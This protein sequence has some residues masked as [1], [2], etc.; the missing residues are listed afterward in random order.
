[1]NDLGSIFD[2]L[3]RIKYLKDGRKHTKK[4]NV[5]QR[6]PT[7]PEIS[8]TNKIFTNEI[9]VMSKLASEK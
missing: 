5:F 8:S 1:M 4:T 7:K 9:K 6:G 3:I 2:F